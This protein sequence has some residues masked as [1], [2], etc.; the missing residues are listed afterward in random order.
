M[1]HARLPTLKVVVD[2]S[3][4]TSRLRFLEVTAAENLDR[5]D[6]DPIEEAEALELMVQEAG[7]AA[8]VADRLGKPEGWVS[9]RRALLKLIPEVREAMRTEEEDQRRSFSVVRKWPTKATEP[10]QL[11]LLEQWR[12]GTTIFTA[13]KA[14]AGGA[15]AAQPS[16]RHPLSV[17]A[18]AMPQVRWRLG[19]CGQR[20][21]RDLPDDERRQLADDCPQLAEELLRPDPA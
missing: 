7:S 6:R 20:L 17:A 2:D 9:Q 16:R 13:V 5:D 4:A 8:A 12:T 14:H 10:Q 19:G 15:P 11:Q 3:W 21:R 1:L 18:S